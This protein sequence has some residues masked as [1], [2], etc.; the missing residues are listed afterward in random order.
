MW[1]HENEDLNKVASVIIHKGL[2]LPNVHIARVQRKTGSV[3]KPG[4][5]KVELSTDAEVRQVLKN[6]S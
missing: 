2:N 3:D 1:Y 5:I 4:L 6:K